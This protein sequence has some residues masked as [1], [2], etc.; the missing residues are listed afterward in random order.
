MA[1]TASS[2]R[3]LREHHSDRYV[4]KAK[5]EGYRSRAAYKLLEIQERDRLFK[6]GMTV[7]DLGAAPG[8]WSQVARKLVGDRGTVIASDILPMPSIAG[9][10]FVQGDFS[11]AEVIEQVLQALGE[12]KVDLVLSD[13]APNMSGVKAV[14]QARHMY[15]AECACECACK[16]L[17]VGGSFLAKLFHGEGFDEYLRDLRQKFDKVHVRKPK[18]SRGRS[19]EAYVLARGYSV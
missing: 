6:P 5:S 7:L 11:E 9:V 15:L 17:K 1:K 8:G 12:C 18:A 4:Q 2:K 19:S 10:A 3:W 16:S 14:D 13:M